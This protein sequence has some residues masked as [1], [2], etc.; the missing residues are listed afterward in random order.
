MKRGKENAVVRS[1]TALKDAMIEM[2]KK[3]LG[4]VTV[5]NGKKQLKGVITEGDIRRQ[6]ECGADIY[7][8]H[9]DEIMTTNPV[10]MQSGQ[11]AVE[12]L[13]IMKTDKRIS[14]IPILKDNIP[15]GTI[16]L[17]DILSVGILG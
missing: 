4:I 16:Q 12:A 10:V 1:G 5:V 17:H 2:G 13:D 15:I 9:V 6:L 8:L 14:S 7:K 11:M 3:R